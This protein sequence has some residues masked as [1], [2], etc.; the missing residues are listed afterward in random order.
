MKIPTSKVGDIQMEDVCNSSGAALSNGLGRICTVVKPDRAFDDRGDTAPQRM[1]KEFGGKW[2]DYNQHYILQVAGCPLKCWYCYVDNL[3]PDVEMDADEVVYDFYYHRRQAQ[4]CVINGDV[5]VLPLM[6]GDP[7]KYAPFWPELRRAMNRSGLDQTIL[8]S[9]VV[10]VENHVYGV[11]P[12]EHMDL[13]NFMLTGCLKGTNRENFRE[14]AGVDLFDQ[15]LRELEKYADKP[16]FY[17]SLINEDEKDLPR[18]LSIIPKE[19]IDFLEVV[20]YEVT[21]SRR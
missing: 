12:W 20:D 15:S 3:Q 4:K 6:G 1:A 21:K 17:L 14:N 2:Q 16:N 10:F 9:D 8:F 5:N 7:G 18:I 13:P 11:K 19:R